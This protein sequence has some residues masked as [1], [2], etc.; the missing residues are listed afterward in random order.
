MNLAN[1]S[2]TSTTS[3][4]AQIDCTDVILN[5]IAYQITNM[6][7]AALAAILIVI[8][9]LEVFAVILPIIIFLILRKWR[10][11]AKIYY[12]SIAISNIISFLFQDL[13]FGFLSITS[14][15]N[16]YISIFDGFAII[17][18][19]FNLLFGFLKKSSIICSTMYYLSDIGPL[20][21]YWITLIFTL[22]KMLIVLYPLKSQLIKKIFNTW[23]LLSCLIFV[24]SLYI[25]DFWLFYVKFGR[26]TSCTTDIYRSREFWSVYYAQLTYVKYI[27]PIIVI[28]GSILVTCVKIIRARNQR[29]QFVKNISKRFNSELRSTIIMIG[30]GA[31]YLITSIPYSIVFIIL[32]FLSP[33]YTNCNTITLIAA[34]QNLSGIFLYL[35]IFSRVADGLMMF[36]IPEFRKSFVN[37]FRCRIHSV[38]AT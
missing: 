26:V 11:V 8:A 25:P 1:S 15:L 27:A 33:D 29:L 21:E 5:S 24:S 10:N 12:Y 14:Y 3:Q 36:M 19:Y 13:T 38:D 37:V 30:F 17:N 4:E 32:I 20:N 28:S 34:L 6:I 35:P 22:N 7:Q 18:L 9:P 16:Q 23:T 2:T 31:I